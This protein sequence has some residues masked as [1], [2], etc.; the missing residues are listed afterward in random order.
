MKWSFCCVSIPPISWGQSSGRGISK[1][2]RLGQ[3]ADGARTRWKI[4]FRVASV[5]DVTITASSRSGRKASV[6]IALDCAALVFLSGVFPRESL[7]VRFL[8]R[9]L[10]QFVER[11]VLHSVLQAP[12]SH[13]RSFWRIRHRYAHAT[14][15]PPLTQMFCPLMNDELS[16]ARNTITPARS[17]GT[18]QRPAGT[19]AK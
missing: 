13:A 9:L 2:R 17:S 1:A 8:S 10:L 11:A 4:S 16:L 19:A 6:E 5:N 7:R 3:W 12:G 18:P 14:V 15:R